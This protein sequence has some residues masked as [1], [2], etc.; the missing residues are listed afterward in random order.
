MHFFIIFFFSE[1]LFLYFPCRG[2]GI[3]MENIY[4]CLISSA[5]CHNHTDEFSTTGANSESIFLVRLY[6]A[7]FMLILYVFLSTQNSCDCVVKISPW[8]RVGK[9]PTMQYSSSLFLKNK[10]FFCH[11][12]CTEPQKSCSYFLFSCG[13]SVFLWYSRYIFY[14][15]VFCQGRYHKDIAMYI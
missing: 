7:I 12:L 9:L 4:P 5:V 13:S 8:K 2:W 14:V 6:F 1:I 3:K 10:W 15:P 11:F